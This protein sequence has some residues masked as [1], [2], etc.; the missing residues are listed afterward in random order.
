VAKKTRSRPA[1]STGAVSPRQPCPCGSG[2]RYKACHGGAD[3]PFVARTFA[4]LPSECDWVAMREFVPAAIAPVQIRDGAYGGLAAGRVVRFAT[5]LPGIAAARVRADEVIE[6]ALQVTYA[7]G[8]TSADLSDA[9]QAALAADPG[10]A[11]VSP[12]QSGA[13]TRLQDVVEPESD[14]AVDVLD[15]FDFW[16]D[17]VGDA[18]GSV[19]AALENLNA[20]VKPTHRLTSVEAAYW[21]SVGTKEHLRWVL[22]YDEEAGLTAL[23]RLH[24]AAGDSLTPQSRLVG[25]FR[26]HGLLVPVWDL[27]VG[28]GADAL[29]EPASRLAERIGEALATDGAL[30][31]KERAARAGLATRQVTLR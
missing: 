24:V 15:G 5:V 8:D 11:V 30:T 2:R 27:P 29:E 31:A 6:V 26:A 7:S 20:S 19:A 17:G 1:P 16:F 25:S 4:G 9:L 18:D 14:F 21:T 23:A 12:S 10:T 28:T 3:V 22:P 13:G